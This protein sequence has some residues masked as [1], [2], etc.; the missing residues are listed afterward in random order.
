[1]ADHD[2][3]ALNI[4]HA[5]YTIED[6]IDNGFPLIL[7]ATLMRSEFIRVPFPAAKIIAL[8]MDLV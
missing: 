1:M 7:C 5:I 4:F 3:S 6:V 2:V 8:I